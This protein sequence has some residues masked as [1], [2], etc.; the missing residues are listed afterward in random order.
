MSGAIDEVV[1]FGSEHAA[2][3]LEAWRR[4]GKGRHAAALNFGDC[5]AYATARMHDVPLLYTGEDFAQTDIPAVDP[6]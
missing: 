4:F 5:L 2:A 3:A 1:P 6:H